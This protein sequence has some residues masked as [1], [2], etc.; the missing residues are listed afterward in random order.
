MTRNEAVLTAVIAVLAVALIVVVI[1]KPSTPTIQVSGVSLN[2]NTISQ[3]AFATL[4]FKIKNNDATK[5]HSVH[6]GFDETN[7]SSVTV[8]QGNQSL[9][10]VFGMS[11]GDGGSKA[12][13]LW[14]TVQPSQD[15]AFS[16]RVTGTLSGGAST[17]AFS[18]PF[19][20]TDENLT[21]F[22]NETVS[23]TVNQ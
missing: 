14:V 20:F 11:T 22:D 15:T 7:C 2:P 6:V 13:F 1:P 4:S 9:D 12:Q 16:F 8:Y 23:L 5:Q 19:Y 10:T 18:I 17:T 21:R 3:N